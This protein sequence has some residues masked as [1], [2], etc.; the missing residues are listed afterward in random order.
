MPPMWILLFTI[1]ILWYPRG[2]Y[3]VKQKRREG[4]GNS[5]EGL[6]PGYY[7]VVSKLL[8]QKLCKRALTGHMGMGMGPRLRHRPIEI[9]GFYSSECVELVYQVPGGLIRDSLT[10]VPLGYR[11]SFEDDGFG[12]H[13]YK[14]CSDRLFIRQDASVETRVQVTAVSSGDDDGC[15]IL[16][17]GHTWHLNCYEGGPEARMCQW[18]KNDKSRELFQLKPADNIDE[19]K[20]LRH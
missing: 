20:W 18:D 16:H 17:Q 5:C 3:R 7:H 13:E 19:S 12:G 15:C 2:G 14:V 10:G 6:A 4:Q 9:I 1:I 8:G 11:V